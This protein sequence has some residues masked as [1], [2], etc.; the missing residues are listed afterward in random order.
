MT[1]KPGAPPINAAMKAALGIAASKAAHAA[2]P[3]HVPAVTPADE[4][5][6]ITTDTDTDTEKERSTAAAAAL[7]TAAAVIDSAAATATISAV[8]R[9]FFVAPSVIQKSVYRTAAALRDA[10][11]AAIAEA[12][13]PPPPGGG[14]DDDSSDDEFNTGDPDEELPDIDFDTKA[15]LSDDHTSESM[16]D[17]HVVVTTSF[18]AFKCN[19]VTGF[20]LV[21]LQD[22]VSKFYGIV[23]NCFNMA[24]A[25]AEGLPYEDGDIGVKP[26]LACAADLPDDVKDLGIYAKDI[27]FNKK[28]EKIIFHARFRSSMKITELK[29]TNQTKHA[30]AKRALLGLIKRNKIW[31][32]S[33]QCAETRVVKI[34]WFLLSHPTDGLDQFKA[35]LHAFWL[36]NGIDIP[37]NLWQVASRRF[38]VLNPRGK[39]K[40]HVETTAMWIDCGLPII[41][42]FRDAC[43]LV[44]ASKASESEYPLLWN[45]TFISERDYMEFRD[46]FRFTAAKK[47]Q[48]FVRE[49]FTHNIGGI[50]AA[51][52]PYME[53]PIRN[54]GTTESPNITQ[55]RSIASLI[56]QHAIA[57]GSN[58]QRFQLFTKLQLPAHRPD[59]WQLQGFRTSAGAARNWLDK[60]LQ[61]LLA[62]LFEHPD[63]SVDGNTSLADIGAP[64]RLMDSKSSSSRNAAGDDARGRGS[65]NERYLSAATAAVVTPDN[66]K[67]LRES[68]IPGSS[69]Y[70]QNQRNKR[71]RTRGRG[72]ASYAEVI[73][74]NKEHESAV[75]E[76]ELVGGASTGTPET[77]DLTEMDSVSTS[78]DV[79]AT[80]VKI[81]ALTKAVERMAQEHK[82]TKEAHARAQRDSAEAYR[83][84]LEEKFE[85]ASKSQCESTAMNTDGDSS[86]TNSIDAV[87]GA[88]EKI[89]K[90]QKEMREDSVK[91]RDAMMQSLE[92]MM[93]SK[94]KAADTEW[95]NSLRQATELS[96]TKI[97]EYTNTRLLELN[98][99]FDTFAT[100]LSGLGGFMERVDKHISGTASSAAPNSGDVLMPAV[101]PL[102]KR[103]RAIDPTPNIGTGGIRKLV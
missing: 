87:A 93:E 79:G 27:R 91:E 12:T 100:Q 49:R 83:K 77:I 41:N 80:A 46:E 10:G 59:Q 89:A 68:V 99:K 44:V 97:M 72:V 103:G 57:K 19:P 45:C 71:S 47:Q 42:R 73:A 39:G 58:G 63:N 22:V 66:V 61:G 43:R 11:D 5:E 25:H 32:G 48:S 26:T 15:E 67:K 37:I 86:N 64:T 36:S 1:S 4:E 51:T 94:I 76:Q 7:A 55:A 24:G 30:H 3:P 8:H 21:R 88:M 2:I 18:D 33:Q 69:Q 38:K 56:I 75:V 60:N 70:T 54:I 13:K 28:T 14:S 101:D 62:K 16:H 78:T 102:G 31:I 50:N 29:K 17:H 85:A 74:A 9:P 20:P 52:N 95:S 90:E 65:A 84:L 53:C 40:E 98:A 96:Q 82:E 6:M 34:G 35:Q 92:A 23:F 81:D